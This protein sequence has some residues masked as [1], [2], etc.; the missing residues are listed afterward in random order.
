METLRALSI[1]AVVPAPKIPPKNLLILGRVV[2][3][4]VVV[5]VELVIEGV[6]VGGGLMIT[7]SWVWAWV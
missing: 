4:V 2:V 6:I 5:V 7:F 1:R 3:A